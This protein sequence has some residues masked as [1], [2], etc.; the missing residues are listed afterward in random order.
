MQCS[1]CCSNCED[2]DDNY[3]TTADVENVT[4][5][6]GPVVVEDLNETL[7]SVS[8]FSETSGS[9]K[10]TFEATPISLE[11]CSITYFAGYL[12]KK[13][14]QKFN[15]EMC[16][17]NLITKT[18]KNDENQ[19]LLHNKT[20][21]YTDQGYGLKA[22]T[23]ILLDISTICLN[24]FKNNF[25]EMKCN[26]K[27]LA[28]LISKAETKIEDKYSILQSNSCKEHFQY[29]IE[30]LLRTKLYKECKWLNANSGKRSMQ[31]ADKLRVLQ[32]I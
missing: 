30:L 8:S 1:T 24:V 23:N 19:L 29:I 26:K 32:N 21:D 12:A 15:C 7:E 4:V 16:K 31:N 13:C 18:N 11:T 20:Y 10:T 6:P 28:Q 5:V 14:I 27:L 3:L 22:P 17:L 9:P 2:D 25:D